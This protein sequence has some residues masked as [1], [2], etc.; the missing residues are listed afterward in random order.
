MKM[1]ACRGRI[2]VGQALGGMVTIL[3]MLVF[4]QPTLAGGDDHRT[5]R[6]LLDKR[7]FTQQEYDQAVQAGKNTRNKPRSKRT[8]SRSTA[9]TE[10]VFQTIGIGSSTYTMLFSANND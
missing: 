6:F 10:P 7:I 2:T 8:R 1:A 4:T 5:L 3:T 9:C